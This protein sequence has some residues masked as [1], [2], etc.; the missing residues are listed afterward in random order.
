MNTASA[1][2]IAKEHHETLRRWHVIWSRTVLSADA[3]T[4]G[5][6]RRWSSSSRPTS[7]PDEPGPRSCAR[8]NSAERCSYVC[9]GVA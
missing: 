5:A 1:R 7:Q 8:E 6:G 4:D 9:Q 3:T 2:I